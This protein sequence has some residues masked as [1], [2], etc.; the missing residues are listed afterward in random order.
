MRTNNLAAARA[1]LDR[2]RVVLAAVEVG[3]RKGLAL[4]QNDLA[5]APTV[6]R[7]RQIDEAVRRFKQE[8]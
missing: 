7:I 8:A 2:S 5:L 4:T 3:R 6:T 1:L